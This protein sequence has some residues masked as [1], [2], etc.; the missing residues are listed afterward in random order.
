M[1]VDVTEHALPDEAHGL[2]ALDRG[3]VEVEHAETDPVEIQLV[4][5]DSD[6]FAHH[7]RAVAVPAFGWIDDHA[8]DAGRAVLT[9]DVGEFEVAHESTVND[10]GVRPMCRS[11]VLDFVEMTTKLCRVERER[12]HGPG[13]LEQCRRRAGPSDDPFGVIVRGLTKGDAHVGPSV[14]AEIY[15]VGR[16]MPSVQTSSISSMSK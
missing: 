3:L 15:R 12:E 14:G 11:R 16:P 10:G 8:R 13:P 4:E 1:S 2:V 6:D 5:P 7:R 9:I